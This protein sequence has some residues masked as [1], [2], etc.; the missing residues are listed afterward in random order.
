MDRRLRYGPD[1]D[2][3]RDAGPVAFLVG[4]LAAAAL[5]LAMA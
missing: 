5:S 2:A 1:A 4:P 3:E